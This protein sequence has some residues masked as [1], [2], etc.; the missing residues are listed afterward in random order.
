VCNVA[1]VVLIPSNFSIAIITPVFTERILQNPVVAILWISAIA[2]ENRRMIVLLATFGIIEKSSLEMFQFFIEAER[3]RNW[4]NS[5]N[6]V[7]NR[8]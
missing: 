5:S 7:S 8:S 6:D 1:H 3:D 2:N 4:S